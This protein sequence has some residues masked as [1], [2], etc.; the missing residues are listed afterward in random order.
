MNIS[1][2]SAP[3]TF[4]VNVNQASAPSSGGLPANRD[5]LALRYLYSVAVV[6]PTTR[7]TRADLSQYI[8]VSNFCNTQLYASR[9]GRIEGTQPNMVNGLP[10]LGKLADFSWL[11]G[12][13]L[14]L[15]HLF[16]DSVEV[17]ILRNFHANLLAEPLQPGA[18]PSYAP[19]PLSHFRF[20]DQN[21][22]SVVSEIPPNALGTKDWTA[23]ALYGVLVHQDTTVHICTFEYSAPGFDW[24]LGVRALAISFTPLSDDI[25]SQLGVYWYGLS[26]PEKR[27][28]PSQFFL[29]NPI[30]PIKDSPGFPG[31]SP[32]KIIEKY[33]GPLLEAPDSI[34]GFLRLN[35]GYVTALFLVGCDFLQTQSF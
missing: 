31:V 8:F 28:N 5:L 1:V 24:A 3:A 4:A 32:I 2:S 35:N 11:R 23:N 30:G 17:V 34:Q 13:S 14:A 12:S 27:N 9:Q 20:Y 7:L 29:F 25:P 6:G 22:N 10:I 16:G 26:G 21:D 33:S 15:Q 19:V 18:V